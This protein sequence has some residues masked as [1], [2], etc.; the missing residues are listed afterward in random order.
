MSGPWEKF[1]SAPAEPAA[2]G[3]W[4]K[5]QAEPAPASDPADWQ[6]RVKPIDLG[7]GKASVQR[8]DGGV[9]FGPEQGNRGKAGWFDANGNRLGDAPG[10]G[11]SFMDTLTNDLTQ[12]AKAQERLPLMGQIVPG[13]VSGMTKGLIDTAVAPVQL[14]A[15]VAGSNVVDPLVDALDQNYRQ[16]WQ[17]SKGGEL[18]GQALPFLA[19]MGGSAAAQAPAQVLSA[20]Q[21][22][23]AA[24]ASL[25]AAAP[26]TAT[27]VKGTLGGATLAPALTPETNVQSE[28]D[29]WSRKRGEAAIGGVMGGGLAAVGVGVGSVAR[30]LKA[31]MAPEAQA[32]QDLGDQFGVRTLAPDLVANRPGLAKTAVL[33]ES[34]P[35]SG[36]VAQ[37]TAQQAE[38]KAAAEKLLAQH[39]IEGDVATT[40]QQGLKNKLAQGKAASRAA[41][42][43]V[44][45]LADGKGD[46]PL[47]QTLKAIREARAA[48]VSA[49]VPDQGLVGL[50]GKMEERLQSPEVNKSFTGARGLRSDLG[51]MISDYYKGTN[52][53][54]GSKGVS[55]LQG[56]KGSL[57]DDLAR[58]TSNSGPEIAAAAKQADSIY[59]GQVVPFKDQ[60]LAKAVKSSEPDQI[61]K[62]MIQQ[63]KGDRA[64]KFYSAL[65]ADG[66]AAVRSQM[67]QD[68]ME[69]A[70]AQEGVFSPAKFAQSLEKIRESTGVFFKGKDRFEL[71]GFTNLMRHI[72]RA[73]QINEN[74]PTGARMLQPILMGQIPAAGT[75]ALLGHPGA[76]AAP[77]VSAAAGRAITKLFSSPAGKRFLLS[78]SSHKSGSAALDDL[79]TKQVPAIIAAGTPTNVQPFTPSRLPA[80]AD[81]SNPDTVARQ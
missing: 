21:R 61:F 58:F 68:A 47:D 3:P 55:V 63:G 51:S 36:M 79:I 49:V 78:A 30:R 66:Q 27:I 15:H 80:A 43:E 62:T 37:R 19:T 54:T 28:G 25:Q 12:K 60:I 20:T 59:R 53:A 70:T 38:A 17:T 48:E 24:L 16:N 42:D 29:Y 33:A 8:D 52:A 18:L 31:P 45:R 14:A 23:K 40:I 26:K 67:V 13:Q 44:A 2:E 32:I 4:S 57:E 5:F 73:G 10:K 65:D 71:D 34:V 50:L 35:G 46:V 11:A 81:T 77:V 76:L 22:V 56:I 9:W 7:G 1:Q 39:G 41:Y 6:A 72:Q 74:P 64:M 69:A 75:A